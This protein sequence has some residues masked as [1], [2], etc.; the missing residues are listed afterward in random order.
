MASYI[1]PDVFDIKY[2]TNHRP[3]K[4]LIKYARAYIT[5]VNVTYNATS[6]SFFANGM[7]SEVDLSL[8][9]HETKALSRE[10]IQPGY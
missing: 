2:L 7:P 1:F 10:D 5:A 3:N 6:P 9:F 8:T 4:N